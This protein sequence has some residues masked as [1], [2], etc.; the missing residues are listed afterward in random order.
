MRRALL[1]AVLA[2]MLVVP[3]TAI[4][5]G[6]GTAPVSVGVAQREFHIT[7]YRRS[8]PPGGVKLNIRNFG[9]DVHNL[10]VRG[11]GGFTAVGPDVDPGKSASWTVKLRK[12]GSYQL[13]C[14]RANHLALGMKST[15]TVAKPKP[16]KRRR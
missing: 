5:L 6:G 7:P 2:A 13:L 12:P 4:A 8:V 14:M 9:Q 16:A 15:L 10:V 3:A 1:L 11:P